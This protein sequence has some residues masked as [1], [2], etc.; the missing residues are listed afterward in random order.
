MTFGME[1]GPHMPPAEAGPRDCRTRMLCSGPRETPCSPLRVKDT[2]VWVF[3]QAFLQAQACGDDG[4]HNA[5]GVSLFY[6]TLWCKGSNFYL[7][8]AITSISTRAPR[9]SPF[10]PMALRAGRWSGK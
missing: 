5:G 9:A 8:T 6:K 4:P 7:T 10:T 1:A 2:M 3:K